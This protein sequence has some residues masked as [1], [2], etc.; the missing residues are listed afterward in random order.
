MMPLPPL[1]RNLGVFGTASQSTAPTPAMLRSRPGTGKG[2]KR[3]NIVR[4]Q[5]KKAKFTAEE[6]KSQREKWKKY[7]GM[8]QEETEQM[9]RKDLATTHISCP[10]CKKTITRRNLVRHRTMQ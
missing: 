3:Y 9:L 8:V 5:L 4:G 1:P 7:V 10:D 6:K 2:G